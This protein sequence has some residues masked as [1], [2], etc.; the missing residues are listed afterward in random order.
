MQLFN[1]LSVVVGNWRLATYTWRQ[2]TA[3]Y[4]KPIASRY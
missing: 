3:N 1:S 2:P 4:K